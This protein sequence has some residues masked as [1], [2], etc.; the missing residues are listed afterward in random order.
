MATQGFFKFFDISLFNVFKKKWF[1]LKMRFS[2][3][4]LYYAI[5]LQKNHMESLMAGVEPFILCAEFLNVDISK[6]AVMA[7]L[8][9]HPPYLGNMIHPGALSHLLA[10]SRL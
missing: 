8:T 10:G 2:I 5:W 1:D 4:N 6:I 3:R 9:V 7:A